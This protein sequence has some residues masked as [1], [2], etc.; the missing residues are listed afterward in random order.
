[1]GTPRQTD[2]FAGGK[3]VKHSRLLIVSL[4][5]VAALSG[6]GSDNGPTSL[7]NSLDTTPPPAPTNI[8][9]ESSGGARQLTWDASAASDLA[10]YEVWQAAS[11]TGSF[12]LA[13]NITGDRSSFTL[14]NVDAAT[15]IDFRVRAYDVSG[16]R[17]AYSSQLSTELIPLASGSPG[18]PGNGRVT[19]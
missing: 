12:V 7:Q 1:M 13:G 5:A 16:N 4:A 17:S 9:V 11:G 18:S 8:A 2:F 3:V 19:P 10:G 15:S 14:P 6:C